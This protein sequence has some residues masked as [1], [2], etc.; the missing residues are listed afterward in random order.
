M[1]QSK[2]FQ[3]FSRAAWSLVVLL[4]FNNAESAPFE[5]LYTITVPR[6]FGAGVRSDEEYVPLAMGR[7]LARVT[8][9]TSAFL[10]PNL[11]DLI[12]NADDYVVDKG[13]PDL[14]GYRVTFDDRAILESLF[15]RNESVWVGE[16]PVTLLWIAVDTG[17]GEQGIVAVDSQ[18]TTHSADYLA[19]VD[20]VRTQLEAVASA[21]GLPIKFPLWDFQDM[22]AL[23]FIDVWG[24]VSDRLGQSSER[25]GIDA[26]L[27]GRVWVSS[28]GLEVQWTLVRGSDRFI[29]PGGSLK[30]GLEQLADLYAGEFSSTGSPTAL[31][32]TVMDLKTIEDYARVMRYIEG[33][34]ERHMLESVDIE[35]FSVTTL[36]LR[37]MARGG[38][39]LL[40]RVLNLSDVLTP[41]ASMSD[42]YSDSQL[43]FFLSR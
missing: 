4:M 30:S 23:D 5:N 18:E 13:W 21:R 17:F 36:T 29:L 38:S 33:L 8:G 20:E 2:Y 41:A 25:Y 28:R 22:D 11:Q 32:I 27:N 37:M 24:G 10:E 26:I 12:G 19:V 43:T 39:E 40:E 1:M 35:E 7:L 16:R 6:D 3:H 31:K 15:Q 34:Q 14:E 42:E 9:R